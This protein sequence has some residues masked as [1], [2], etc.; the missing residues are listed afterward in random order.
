MWLRSGAWHSRFRVRGNFGRERCSLLRGTWLRP[1]PFRSPA[2]RA[3][4]GARR[5]SRGRPHG[6][7]LRGEVERFGDVGPGDV[8]EVLPLLGRDV[9]AVLHHQQA[10]REALAKRRA[11]HVETVRLGRAIHA[12]GGIRDDVEGAD[13][14][15]LATT[16][17]QD[18]VVGALVRDDDVAAAVR[19]GPERDALDVGHE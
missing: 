8:L 14:S 13:V 5:A 3:P 10:L 9:A 19:R 12:R 11:R 7:L 4:T 15:V 17:V 18:V 6:G 2:W 1:A 16:L